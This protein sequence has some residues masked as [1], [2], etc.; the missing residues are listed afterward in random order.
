M[1][2][3]KDESMFLTSMTLLDLNDAFC[4]QKDYHYQKAQSR[5]GK[6]PGMVQALY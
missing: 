4:A 2:W 1:P 6:L 3:K 5:W